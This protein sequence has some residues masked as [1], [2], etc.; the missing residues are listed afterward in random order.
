MTSLPVS[1]AQG[2]PHAGASVG[3]RGP[4]ISVVMPLHD[5]ERFVR[6]A[7]ESV[8]A[9]TLSDFELIVV[10]D[11]STDASAS[12]VESISDRRIRLVRRAHSGVARTMN[13][14]IGLA[15]GRYI[16]IMDADEIAYPHRFER[17]IELLD[18]H[19]EIG[20]VSCSYDLIDE[21]GHRINTLRIPF[22]WPE[23]RRRIMYMNFMMN[24]NVMIRRSALPSGPPYDPRW[25]LAPDHDLWARISRK[26]HLA[27]THEVLCGSRCRPQGI[28][29]TH[30]GEQAIEVYR[31]QRGLFRW[32]HP[33]ERLADFLF[34]WF[35]CFERILTSRARHTPHFRNAGYLIRCFQAVCERRFRD[36]W[37]LAK[38]VFMLSPANPVGALVAGATLVVRALWVPLFGSAEKEPEVLDSV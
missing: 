14:G 33:E 3:G 20:V 6:E 17:Q 10:D 32:W 35:I 38:H 29:A 11:G 9:Q 15:R 23:V 12:I 19:P 13:A 27:V 4:R 7:V 31:I 1:A 8:L 24:S 5:C 18:R 34:A 21:H 25:L 16:A 37:N 22:P 26:W 28:T 36:A 2:D 30:T